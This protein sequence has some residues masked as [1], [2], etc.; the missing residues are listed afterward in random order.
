MS[1]PR[2]KLVYADEDYLNHLAEPLSSSK[3]REG[4]LPETGEIELFREIILKY[5]QNYGRSFSWRE[6]SDPYHILL[7][8]LML[9]QTQTERAAPK[10]AAFIERW[11]DFRALSEAPFSEI[12]ILWKGLG[13]NRRAMALKQI[14]LTAMQQYEGMLPKT[15]DELLKLPMIGPATASA[16]MAFSYNEPALYL[17]TNIRRVLLHFFYQNEEKVHDRELYKVLD[18]VQVREDPKSWYYALMDYGVLL[19][20]TVKNPNRRSAHYTKQPAFEN[21]N[22]QIR[23]QILTVFTEKGLVSKKE[24][25]SFLKFSQKKIDNCLSA[26]QKEGFVIPLEHEAAE[27]E[28]VYRI[29]EAI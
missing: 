25:Y 17:E 22:R 5:Y 6:T 11:P 2:A 4:Q 19:K 28:M 8:E 1:V 3:E 14:S 26:L 23:G 27:Q 18:A 20:K 16:V 13:Y 29:N 12:L 10:Y 21:S 15:Y 9:Q 24:L 7:S